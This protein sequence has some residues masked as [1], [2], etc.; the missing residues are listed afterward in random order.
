[1]QEAL[2]NPHY[3]KI[4]ETVN[5][6]VRHPEAKSLEEALEMES[7]FDDSLLFHTYVNDSRIINSQEFTWLSSEIYGED[8]GE[9]VTLGRQITLEDVL[10]LLGKTFIQTLNGYKF[11][12]LTCEGAFITMQPIEHTLHRIEVI[13][14]KPLHEQT[15]ETWEKIANLID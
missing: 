1:M 4:W 6:K 7:K 3:K 2:Q 9:N 5:W 11:V 8:K 12:Q 15:P 14:G 10:M 13:L